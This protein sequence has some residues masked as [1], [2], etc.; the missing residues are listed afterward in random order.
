MSNVR[1]RMHA[2][3]YDWLHCF[4]LLGNICIYFWVGSREKLLGPNKELKMGI[5]TTQAITLAQL[6]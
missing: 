3:S 1:M 5:H 6:H 4:H 2:F